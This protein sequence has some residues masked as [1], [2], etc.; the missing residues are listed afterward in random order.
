MIEWA[1]IHKGKKIAWF[2]CPVQADR[3]ARF[4]GYRDFSVEVDSV[5]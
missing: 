4:Y 1:V 5:G 2:P 3:W